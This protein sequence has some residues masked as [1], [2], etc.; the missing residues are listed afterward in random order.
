MSPIELSGR[1]VEQEGGHHG[2]AL[3]EELDL[4]QCHCNRHQLLLTP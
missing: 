1:I 4:R 3:L 2:R